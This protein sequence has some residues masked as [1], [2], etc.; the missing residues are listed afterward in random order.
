MIEL[1]QYCRGHGDKQLCT[2]RSEECGL[3]RQC[4]TALSRSGELTHKAYSV[5][6]R[7]F[8]RRLV[9]FSFVG[10]LKSMEV[11]DFFLDLRYVAWHVDFTD[12]N[13]RNF[14]F[15]AIFYYL[16]INS[17]IKIQLIDFKMCT[18]VY[19]CVWVREREGGRVRESG[20]ESERG[21]GWED[22][23]EVQFL[24]ELDSWLGRSKL[25]DCQLWQSYIPWRN[26]DSTLYIYNQHKYLKS[27]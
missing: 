14:S 4:R 25:C 5:L 23:L 6:H 22:F 17:M 16:S 10:F 24:Y 21:R 12:A 13:A 19:F 11:T 18:C 26:R 7:Y 2:L 20:R 9:E 15:T 27:H 1:F 8:S 3:H